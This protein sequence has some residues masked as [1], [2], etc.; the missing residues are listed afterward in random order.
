[1]T[2]DSPDKIIDRSAKLVFSFFL[3]SAGLWLLTAAFFAYLAA[4]KLTDPFFLS[5]CEFFTY[6]KIKVA[7]A[8]AFV[9]GWG[10]NAIFAVSLW[11]LARLSQAE[12]RGS[13]FL[14][15][16]GV[17]WNLAITFGLLGILDG[18]MS[19]HEMLEMPTEVWPAMLISYLIITFLALVIHRSRQIKETIAPQWFILAALLWFPALFLIAWHGLEIN[20]AR[21]TLQTVLSMWYGQSLIWLWLTPVALGAAYYLIPAVLGRTI[22][23]YYLAIFGFWCIAALAPWS[24]VHHLE[25]GPVPMWIPAI[26]TVMSIAMVFPIAVAST[27]FHATAFL[28]IGKV[29]DSLPLRFVIFGTLSYTVSSYIGVVFSLPAVAKITQFTIINEFH[30]NQRVYGF[31]SMIIFGAVYFA[32]PRITGREI[33]IVAKSFH[34]WT[35]TFGVLLLLLAYLIGGLTHGVLA[36]QPSLEWSSAV[37]GSIQPYFLITKIAFVILAFSQLVFVVNVWRVIFPN[38]LSLLVTGNKEASV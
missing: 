11:I 28:D 18:H 21:G 37:I 1:M 36:G 2:T 24:V 7:Q 33:P 27:N 8:N 38:P 17:I 23:K 10:G 6:G 9:Y 16:A 5:T 30:F 20:T 13:F 22:D 12:V 15:V 31:F 35:S 26:G 3:S 14:I 25:G 4:A 34:F 29:W 32:L 19:G